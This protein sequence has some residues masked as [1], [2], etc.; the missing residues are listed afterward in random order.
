M[1]LLASPRSPALGMG[2]GAG[3]GIE[4]WK[5]MCSKSLPIFP[6]AFW[7][8]P[9]SP[10]VSLSSDLQPR[11]RNVSSAFSARRGRPESIGVPGPQHARLLLLEL[12]YTVQ[13]LG[14][15]VKGAD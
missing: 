11:S 3:G 4:A 12:I 13:G 2:C 14:F 5:G 1:G 7:Q 9:E 15:G 10:H 8:H 6:E